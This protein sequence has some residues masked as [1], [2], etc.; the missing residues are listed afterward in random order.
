[1]SSEEL[2]PCPFCGG[3]RIKAHHI[4]DGRSLGCMDCGAA[5]HKFNGPTD[6]TDALMA[7]WN[8]RAP[9]PEVATLRASEARMRESLEPS[10]DT[11][12]AYM[13]EIKDPETKRMVSWTAIKM[14]MA[15][16]STRAALQG[17]TK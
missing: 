1:M 6:I 17:V 13:G 11:K 8:R 9:S 12:A 2:K 5:V 3:V 15:M 14:V 16:I 10:G 7:K 4:R